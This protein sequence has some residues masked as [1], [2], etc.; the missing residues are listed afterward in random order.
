[1]S[2]TAVVVVSSIC[3]LAGLLIFFISIGVYRVKRR[4]P[5]K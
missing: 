5:H 1:M 3:I 2:D 4:H